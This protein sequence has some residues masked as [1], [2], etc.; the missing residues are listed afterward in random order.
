M[1]PRPP[2]APIPRRDF[3]RGVAATSGGVLLGCNAEPAP[4]PAIV[5]ASLVSTA[6]A[7]PSIAP[8]SV[9]PEHARPVITHGVQSGDVGGG[10]AIVWARADRPARMIVEW[11]TDASFA[12]STRAEGPI[13]EPRSDFAARVDLA[14]LP[15]GVRVHYRVTFHDADTGRAR[16]EPATGSFRTAPPGRA[17]VTFAWGGDTA[18]QGWGINPEWGGMRIYETMRRM[19]PDFFVHCGDLIYA[20]S[21]ILPEVRLPDGSIWRNVTTPEKSKVAETLAELR[22]NFAYNLLDANVRRFN[23]EVPSLVMWDDHEVHNNWYPGQTLDDERYTVK[24][25]SLLSERARQAMFEYTPIRP[26]P[27]DPKRIHRSF[28][29]GPSLDVFL[30]DERAYR[31]PNGPNQEKTPSDRTAFLGKAQLR[32]LMDGLSASKATWKI[33]ATDAPLSL[34][35]GDGVRDGVA[36]YE[37]WANGK[38]PPLGRELELA[39]LFSFIKRRGVKNVAWITA[40]VHYAAAYFHDPRRAQFKDFTPFWQFVAGPLHAS[41]Y[42]PNPLDPTFGPEARYESPPSSDARRAPTFGGQYF[43]TMRVDGRTEVLSVALWDL[44]GAR[45]WSIDLPP[46]R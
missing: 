36:W 18:G 40:D 44:A 4:S 46:L 25:A 32:W 17:D 24:D 42:G 35:V 9:T 45:L 6:P 16:S 5:P 15:A 33:I 21:P 28:N 26:L 43:G 7:A 8:A 12:S 10:R 37:T 29:Y 3:L 34:I 41:T 31:G 27:G 20:D 38:G 1:K 39:E 19:R 30:L 22:G 23:A 11:S 14:D 2:A 13:A